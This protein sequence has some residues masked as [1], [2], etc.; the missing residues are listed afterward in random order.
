LITDINRVA[1]SCT[2]IAGFSDELLCYF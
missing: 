2:A 1:A